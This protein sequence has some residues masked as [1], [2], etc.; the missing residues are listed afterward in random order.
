MIVIV[1]GSRIVVVVTTSTSPTYE[2]I[3]AAYYE[4]TKD[5][6]NDSQSNS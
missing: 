5:R 1:K 2:P 3:N 4:K 6:T